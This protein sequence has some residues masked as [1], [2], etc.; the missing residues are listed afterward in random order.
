[1]VLFALITLVW[2]FAGLHLAFGS[3]WMI[4]V[5][6]VLDAILVSFFQNRHVSNLTVL[7]IKVEEL[8]SGDYF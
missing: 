8:V 5:F 3:E 2:L 7:L 6:T 1:M 4:I